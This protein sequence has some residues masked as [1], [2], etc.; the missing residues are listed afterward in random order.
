MSYHPS[1]KI[2]KLNIPTFSKYF[3][4]YKGHEVDLEGEEVAA[5]EGC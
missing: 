4:H 2:S 5:E 1:C 3:S